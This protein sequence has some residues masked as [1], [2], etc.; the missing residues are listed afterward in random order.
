MIARAGIGLRAPHLDAWVEMWPAAAFLE[1]HAENYLG[2]SPSLT[3]LERLRRDYAFS[4][5][6]VGLSLG[7]ADGIDASHLERVRRLVQRLR[8]ELVS[9]HL[10]WS[11]TGGVYFNDLLPLPCTEEALAVVC[12]NV[13]RMQEALGRQVLIENPSAYLAF[14]HSTM[15]EPEFLAELVRRT[16]CGLLFDVNNVFVSAQNMRLDPQAWLAGVPAEAVAQYHLAGH[17]RNDSDGAEILIDDHGSRVRDEVWDLFR[18]TVSRFGPRPTLMEWDNDIPELAVLL[19]EARL[20]DRILAP[21]ESGN[22][23]PRAA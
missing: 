4:V 21:N 20:A 9:E 22:A 5:H 12:R 10:A 3:S 17:A 2:E 7:S 18:A 23:A 6:G 8:P 16:G 11:V 1:I 19:D 14:R 15:S 13:E